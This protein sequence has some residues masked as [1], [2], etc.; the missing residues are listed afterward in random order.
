MHLDFASE[1]AR[2]S[3]EEIRLLIADRQNLVDE[4]REALDVEIHKR[5][6][7]GFDPDARE[8]GEPRV[9]VEEDEEEGNEVVV[10]SRELVFPKICPRCLSRKAESIVRI[11]CA[12]ASSRGF[13]LA[14]DF[15]SGLWGRLFFRYSVPF[16]RSCATSVRVRRCTETA[17]ILIAIAGYL[18]AAEHFRLSFFVC[19]MILILFIALGGMVWRL[20]DLSKRWPPAGIEILSKWSAR[21][22]RL[23]FANPAYEKAFIALNGGIP[24]VERS[25][26]GSP[27]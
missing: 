2:R 8:A 5:R 13:I 9:H 7:R 1:Y 15:V 6:S 19:L 20:L 11:S 21:E 3:D 22:R 18:Y 16:C 10:C 24:P 17:L 27:G 14:F 12:S 25:G 23:Q 4:A 26:N